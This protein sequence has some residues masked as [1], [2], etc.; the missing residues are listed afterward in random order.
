MSQLLTLAIAATIYEKG[1]VVFFILR[2]SHP[3]LI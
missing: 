2:P 1:T 3:A